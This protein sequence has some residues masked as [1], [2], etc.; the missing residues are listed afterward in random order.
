MDGQTIRR[1]D[2]LKNERTDNQTDRQR[3]NE[4]TDNQT[5][6][7]SKNKPF[8]PTVMFRAYGANNLMG[9]FT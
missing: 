8:L 2:R 1:I 4:R 9:L 6:R 5:D 3:E 7:Q